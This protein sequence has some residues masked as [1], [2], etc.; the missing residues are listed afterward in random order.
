MTPARGLAALARSTGWKVLYSVNLGHFSAARVTADAHR[1]ATVLGP[2]LLAIAC[3]NE[4]EEY[5][6]RYRSSSYSESDYLSA[7][8]PRCAKAVREG[9]PKVPFAGPDTFRVTTWPH[10][11]LSPT[12]LGPYAQ[13]A[14]AGRI[15]GLKL[16]AVHRY[17]LSNCE[18]KTDPPAALISHS[19]ERQEIGLLARIMSVSAKAKVP[20]V[21]SET[22]SAACGGIPGVSNAFASAL[23]SA[24]WLA[25]AAERHAKSA[26]LNGSLD[27]CI[28]Y[29]PL[30]RVASHQYVAA[31]V[32]YGMLFLHMLG[33][34]QLFSTP[35]KVHGPSGTYVVTH[36]VISSSGVIRVMVQNLGRT[37]LSVTLKFGHGSGAGQAWYLT[38][39][40][41]G[42]TSGERIQG[43]AVSGNG[44][45]KAGAPDAVRCAAGRCRL[46][47]PA[48]S[49]VI[50]RLPK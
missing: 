42:A 31:P 45:F 21:I 33:Q 24:D 32:Y 1:V 39:P 8:V 22:N 7:D 27:G 47:L 14:R 11:A 20:Y 49:S 26:D 17:P 41:L 6:G 16:L 25:I 23:W 30:C 38:A 34:G 4:P 5:A 3:G 28:V 50:V 2:S 40:S 12:W 48:Y 37:S 19:V 35:E 44:T 18:G 10:G 29:T 13:A 43:A 46:W 9:A 36:A 15:P